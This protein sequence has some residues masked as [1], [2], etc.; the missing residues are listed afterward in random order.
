MAKF[1]T[2][3]Q[4]QDADEK[5]YINLTGEL[6]KALFKGEKNAGKSEACVSGKEYDN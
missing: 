1:I 2:S 4:L 5:D 3:I 6:E